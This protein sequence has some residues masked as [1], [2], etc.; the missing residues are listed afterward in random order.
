MGNRKKTIPLLTTRGEQSAVAE[1][2]NKIRLL[3]QGSKWSFDET[4]RA[5]SAIVFYSGRKR[6]ERTIAWLEELLD[7]LKNPRFPPENETVDAW[8]GSAN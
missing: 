8:K 3:I 2:A 6:R 4:L 7:D 1:R 5:F